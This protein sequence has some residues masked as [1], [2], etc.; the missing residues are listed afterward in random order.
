MMIKRHRPWL[1]AVLTA[2]AL[3]VAGFA[4]G[5]PGADEAV[6]RGDKELH[7]CH[8][9]DYRQEVLCGSHSVFE[10]REARAGRMIDI[11]FAIVPAVGDPAADPVV[12]FAGGPGQA[13][14]SLVRWV[15]VIF[16]DLLESRDVVLIDQ[17]GLGR[18]HPLECEFPDFD[19]EEEPAVAEERTLDQLRACVDAWDADPSLYT[20]DLANGDIH[21]ILTALGYGPANLYGGS[22]GTRSALLYAHRYPEHVRSVILD[23]ALP[24]ENPA[25]LYAAEDAERA[26]R[27]L[28]DDC[29]ADDACAR[30]FPDLEGDM[31][32]ALA[33]LEDAEAEAGD[34]APRVDIPDPLTGATVRAALDRETFGA[35]LRG[36]LY[37]PEL[38]RLTP[39]LI[40][41]AAQ[42]DYRALTA[43]SSSFTSGLAGSM[44]PAT[45]LAIF[46]A[47]EIPRTGNQRPQPA[48]L[49]GLQ[50]WNA[51]S[52]SCD[53]FPPL[54]T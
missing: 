48:P 12:V 49:I 23:G 51:I 42:G 5:A 9:P 52:G 46:C 20:Q 10:D 26:L 2:A 4:Q 53:A 43:A 25:P 34:V 47:E 50:M 31:R 45:Q 54:P 8:L 38:G 41:R 14:T 44:T 3:P 24:L 17:R 40:H 11:H 19:L 16:E 37:S 28:F 7:Y 35:L 27:G 32:R 22:W 39:W 6:T 1:A 30:A 18:S 13:A 21:D 36:L 29:S 15:P 33:L